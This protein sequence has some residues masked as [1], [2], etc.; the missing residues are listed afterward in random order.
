[1]RQ[2]IY[3]FS[4]LILNSCVDQGS[5]NIEFTLFNQTDKTVKVLG[6]NTQLDF[7]TNGK[8]EPIIINP[9]SEFKV[10]RVTGLDNNTLMGFYSLRS[11]VDSVRVVFENLKVKVYSENISPITEFSIFRGND[12]HQ[13]FITEQDY[14]SAEPCNGNCE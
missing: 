10:T 7:N 6:F 14:E 9:N 4:I 8:A 2:I 5:S 13:H 11:G 12:N 3:L 1:M